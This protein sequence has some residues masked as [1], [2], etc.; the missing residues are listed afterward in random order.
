MT[1]NE[2]RLLH[3]IEESDDP[4]KAMVIAFDI[5]TRF[6]KGDSIDEIKAHCAIG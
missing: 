1:E 2:K 5:L 6:A 4:V 3:M